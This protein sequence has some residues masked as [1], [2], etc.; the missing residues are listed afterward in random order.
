MGRRPRAVRLAVPAAFVAVLTFVA[1]WRV[2]SPSV[3]ASGAASS[4]V[5]PL[6]PLTQIIEVLAQNS[7]GRQASLE[8]VVIQEVVSP[9][10]LWIGEDDH[11]VFVVL[12][13][14]VRNPSVVPVRAGTRVTLIGLVRA[15]PSE[16]EAIRQWAL[17]AAT[18][19]AVRDRGTYLHVTEIRPESK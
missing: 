14:D 5:E 1:L 4:S 10:G 15:A 9:R 6:T 16:D 18:A 11:R 8:R 13:P 7:I 12:D 2:T 3:P 19:K 17:D